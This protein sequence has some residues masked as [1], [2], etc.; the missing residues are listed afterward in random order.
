[1]LD[2]EAGGL[3]E[4]FALVTDDSGSMA[5]SICC[6]CPPFRVYTEHNCQQCAR[7]ET[8]SGIELER[9]HRRRVL[10]HENTAGAIP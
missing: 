6:L 5:S 10:L 9:R 3:D 2:H 4:H 8:H 7:F 1:M